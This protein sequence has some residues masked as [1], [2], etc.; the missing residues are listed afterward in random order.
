LTEPGS[1][2]TSAHTTAARVLRKVLD[3][4]PDHFQITQR[5]GWVVISMNNDWKKIFAF[6]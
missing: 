6:D 5:S 4:L 2:Q 3:G 1:G